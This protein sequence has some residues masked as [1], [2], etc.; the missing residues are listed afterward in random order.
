MPSHFFPFVES[1]LREPTLQALIGLRTVI[2][3][4]QIS[5]PI[6]EKLYKKVQGL[7]E[8]GIPGFGLI[9]GLVKTLP[10]RFG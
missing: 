2:S 10:N 5:V 6:G 7:N 9:A 8:S 3:E 4:L 1:E